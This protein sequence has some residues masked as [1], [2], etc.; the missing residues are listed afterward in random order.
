AWDRP[1]EVLAGPRAPGDLVRVHDTG[2][3]TVS[4]VSRALAVGEEGTSEASA[5]GRSC[6][7][8]QGPLVTI[9]MLK[10]LPHGEVL[11]VPHCLRCSSGTDDSWH[12]LAL[13]C[14]SVEEDDQATNE[15]SSERDARTTADGL[16]S[17]TVAFFRGTAAEWM[18]DADGQLY[19]LQRHGLSGSSPDAWLTVRDFSATVAVYVRGNAAQGDFPA[20]MPGSQAISLEAKM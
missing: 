17:R 8:L 3:G 20:T 16:R 13:V 14:T 10:R 4:E 9:R 12:L 1:H 15:V 19:R 5:A 6:E 7:A 2:W 18:L 11:A